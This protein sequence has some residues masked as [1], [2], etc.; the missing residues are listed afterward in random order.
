MLA[1]QASAPSVEPVVLP[2]PAGPGRERARA[3]SA[4]PHVAPPLAENGLESAAA[5]FARANRA[6]RESDTPRAVALYE[7]LQRRFPSSPEALASEIPMGLLKLSLGQASGALPHFAAYLE[8]APK[9]ELG[10]E[11]LWGQAQALFALGRSESARRALRL[12]LSKHPESAYAGAA[13]AKLQAE[14]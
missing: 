8:R 1:L 14:Q 6:R 2:Q 13:R 12:L 11:A 4:A 3:A 9:G 10:P 5:L 7:R